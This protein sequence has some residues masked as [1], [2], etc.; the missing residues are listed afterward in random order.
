M[1]TTVLSARLLAAVGLAALPGCIFGGGADCGDPPTT[2]PAKLCLDTP[3]DTADTGAPSCPSADE[4]DLAAM[5]EDSQIDTCE[6][7]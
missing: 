6:V 3:R 2:T 4:P 7:A 1:N 5:L